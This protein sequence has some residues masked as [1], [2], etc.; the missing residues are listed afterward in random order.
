M[1]QHNEEGLF[2]KVRVFQ[3]APAHGHELFGSFRD[4]TGEGIG[5]LPTLV[6]E[7]RQ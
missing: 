4:T 3:A 6:Q 1:L 7:K 5:T 2:S